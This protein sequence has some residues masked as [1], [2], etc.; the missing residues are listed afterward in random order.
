LASRAKIEK[1][2]PC[3]IS[4]SVLK[5]E[6]ER[7][8]RKGDLDSDVVY[9]SKLFHVDYGILEKNLRR[10]IERTLPKVSGNPVLVYG[11][12]C[13]GPNGEMK[14]L[15]QEYG[16]AKIDALNCI[17]C[18][19]GGKGKI[20]EVDPYHELMFFD[21]GMIEFFQVMR[22]KLK[23]E[24]MDEEALQNMFSGIKGIVLLDTLGEVEKCKKEIENLHSGLEILEVK[25]VGL[26]NLKLVL[27]DAIKRRPEKKSKR[28][29]M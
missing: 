12:L 17:D 7:L 19:V 8:K 1:T 20:D 29:S 26:E 9:V 4:C 18:L 28:K 27:T 25:Q 23:Q 13:L 15:A 2:K 10:T 3:L 5:D 24:G 6:I 11:D 16:L 14:L 21:P 22:K